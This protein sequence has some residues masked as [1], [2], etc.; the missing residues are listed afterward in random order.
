MNSK[1]DYIKLKDEIKK[2][3]KERSSIGP[4]PNRVL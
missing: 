4:Q 3:K 1:K 2:E